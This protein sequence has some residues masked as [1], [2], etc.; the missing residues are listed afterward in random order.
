MQHA[1]SAA[2][3]AAGRG[4]DVEVIDL[5]SIVPI[6]WATICKSVARTRSLLIVDEDYLGFG[7]SGELITG[8]IERMGMGGMDHIAR[9]GNPGVPVPAALSLEREIVPGEQ[10]ILAAINSAVGGTR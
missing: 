9:H 3:A 4:I 5:R 1:V 7:L 2:H 8:V 10:S 6:D